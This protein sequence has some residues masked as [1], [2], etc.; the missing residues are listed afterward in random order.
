MGACSS[1][2]KTIENEDSMAP[3]E[4][5]QGELPDANKATVDATQKGSS[6]R[7]PQGVVGEGLADK[8]VP[9]KVDDAAIVGAE[10]VHIE[11]E[12]MA[13]AE[14]EP[15]MEGFLSSDE[16]LSASS[17]GEGK[18]GDD[19]AAAKGEVC[20]KEAAIADEGIAEGSLEK[21][22]LTEKDVALSAVQDDFEF[23]A[24]D[25]GQS[26]EPNSTAE[27]GGVAAKSADSAP[28]L[29]EE[30]VGEAPFEVQPAFSSDIQEPDVKGA[31]ISEEKEIESS[32]GLPPAAVADFPEESTIEAKQT[33]PFGGLPPDGSKV[34]PYPAT[35]AEAGS[36][37]ESRAV[38]TLKDSTVDP[39]AAAANESIPEV[40]ATT[41]SEPQAKKTAEE[42]IAECTAELQAGT[43][44]DE[45]IVEITVEP[46]VE[47]TREETYVESIVESQP[48]VPT[49]DEDIVETTVEPQ[50]DTTP[51]EVIVETIIE[52]QQ[53]ATA[54]ELIENIVQPQ[55]QITPEESLVEAKGETTLNEAIAEAHVETTMEERSAEPQIESP[56]P[57][58]KYKN[59][60]TEDLELCTQQANNAS[61]EGEL[62][63]EDASDVPLKA[64]SS[65]SEPHVSEESLEKA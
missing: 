44:I 40:Q 48:E 23:L 37:E 11:R 59:A 39:A 43:T 46:Q 15:L 9:D 18:V 2:P 32:S 35:I 31:D 36:S 30:K 6:E 16:A 52:A 51:D 65:T 61:S 33:M 7:S 20:E 56:P 4:K 60:D 53:E 14:E 45:S 49:L 28:F 47:T 27:S 62:T 8:K 57:E 17:G 55:I 41:A 3:T 22:T 58:V 29:T 5:A 21:G 1:K 13:V 38:G 26:A 19:V 64:E 42:N 50:A 54:D 24:L 63:F 34:D 25:G 10:D 12:S